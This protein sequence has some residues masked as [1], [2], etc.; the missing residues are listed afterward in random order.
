PT[1]KFREFLP[2]VRHVVEHFDVAD[3]AT[4]IQEMAEENDRLWDEIEKLWAEVN[5][6]RG[7]PAGTWPGGGRVPK[8]SRQAKLAL[9]RI[10]DWLEDGFNSIEELAAPRQSGLKLADEL[11]KLAASLSAR[12]S[13]QSQ[14][15]VLHRSTLRDAA[16]DPKWPRT[17]KKQRRFVA[18]SLA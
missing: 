3:A 5:K 10:S 4:E 8:V 13:E 17:P 15:L 16:M 12:F 2:L 14:Y 7:R 9:P 1:P 11:P 18:D 6:L